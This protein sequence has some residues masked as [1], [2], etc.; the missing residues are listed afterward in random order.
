[1]SEEKQASAADVSQRPEP[2][3]YIQHIPE[4]ALHEQGCLILLE[5]WLPT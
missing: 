3:I 5:T 2:T 4:T 1:M